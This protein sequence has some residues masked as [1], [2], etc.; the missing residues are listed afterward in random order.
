MKF[1]VNYYYYTKP[2]RLLRTMIMVQRSTGSS[3]HHDDKRKVLF[4]ILKVSRLVSRSN[5][6]FRKYKCT[7]KCITKRSALASHYITAAT[8]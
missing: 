7:Y 3:T 2:Y 5:V 6:S 1:C 4:Y 8:N